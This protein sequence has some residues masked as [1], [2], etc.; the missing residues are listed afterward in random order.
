MST[1]FKDQTYAQMSLDEQVRQ[2]EARE[3]ERRKYLGDYHFTRMRQSWE[4]AGTPTG[5][6]YIDGEH[7]RARIF[8]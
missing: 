4:V 8:D 6:D 7:I 2:D 5:P 3:R 1:N